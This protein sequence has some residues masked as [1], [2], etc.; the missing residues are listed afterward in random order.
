[1]H[2]HVE[3]LPS[4]PKILGLASLCASVFVCCSADAP[5]N[6]QPARDAA[7]S[8]ADAVPSP[9]A[10]AGEVT[11]CEPSNEVA[12]DYGDTGLKDANNPWNEVEDYWEISENLDGAGGPVFHLRLHPGRGQFPNPIT[13]G[14]YSIGSDDSRLEDCA[15][16]AYVTVDGPNGTSYYMADS[17]TLTLSTIAFGDVVDVIEGSLLE[18]SF[19]AVKLSGSGVDCQ[20]AGECGNTSC[21]SNGQCFVQEE[22]NTCGTT[23]G[24]LRFRTP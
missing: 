10:D 20:P 7:R 8:S 18:G 5:I 22:T 21:A 13:P 14:T 11:P 2:Y 16:C 23:I 17:G 24:E 9:R 3:V 15:L 1:M 6:D 4:S 12:A 19:Q